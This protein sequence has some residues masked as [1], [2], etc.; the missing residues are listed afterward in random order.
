MQRIKNEVRAKCRRRAIGREGRQ[1]DERWIEATK[2]LDFRL[3]AYD[4]NIK[5]EHGYDFLNCNSFSFLPTPSLHIFIP[6]RGLN[7][8]RKQRANQTLPQQI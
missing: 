8:K 1:K 7:K 4:W 6:E 2:D 3:N 5:N